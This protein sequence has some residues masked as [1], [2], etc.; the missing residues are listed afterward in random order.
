[1]AKLLI[2][3]DDRLFVQLYSDRFT[4]EGYDIDVALDGVEGIEKVRADPPDLIM[5]DL[6]M[7][8]S[9]GFEMLEKLKADE[10]FKKIPVV[11]FTN[12]SSEADEE[13]V[14]KMGAV[15][16]LIKANNPPDKVMDAVN[17]I[18]G[19]KVSKE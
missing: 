3:E 8:R 9:S 16:Y 10:Q 15:E 4:Q 12:V 1:M 5:L 11:V 14:R 17:R 7:P 19:A 6:M 13:R 2:V 18:I